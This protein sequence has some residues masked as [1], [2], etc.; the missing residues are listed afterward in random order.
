LLS[1]KYIKLSDERLASLLA[2]GDSKA[3]DVLYDR[4]AEKMAAFFYRMLYQDR[5]LAA[6]FTQNLFMKVFEKIGS[7]DTSYKFSTWIHTLANNLCKNEYRRQERKP[8]VIQ[9]EVSNDQSLS[10]STDI[11]LEQKIFDK[12]LQKAVAA[13]SEK[14][15]V[16]FVL[17]YYEGMSVEEI[18]EVTASP[19]GTVKSRIHYALKSLREKLIVFNPKSKEIRK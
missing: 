18:S 10:G 7:Y 11:I 14:H 3:F 8:N 5:N 12:E 19:E 13:L 16:C 6:D 9:L 1:N 4:Y 15:K 2:I 17:R